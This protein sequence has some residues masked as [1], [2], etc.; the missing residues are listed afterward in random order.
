MAAGTGGEAGAGAVPSFGALASG[1][2]V[3]ASAALA[4]PG[5]Y[6]DN[7]IPQTTFRLRNDAEFGINQFDRASWMFGTWRD[8]S[9]NPKAFVNGNSVHGIYFSPKSTG[10][11]I[12]SNQVN[13]DVL[14]GYAEYAFGQRFSVF[15]EVPY[16]FVHFGP[17]L[18]NMAESPAQMSQFPDADVA[19]PKQD[20]SGISDLQFGFKYAVIAEDSRYVTFQFRTYAPTGDPGL[21]LGTGHYSLEPSLLLYQRLTDRVITQGELEYWIPISGGPGAGN[22]L[23]YGAGISYDLVQRPGFR[24]TPV[25]EA[26]GWTVIGGTEAFAG[27]IPAPI[28]QVPYNPTVSAINVNGVFVPPDRGFRSAT[29]DTIVNLKI[30]VRT[31]FRSSDVYIGYGHS[32]TGSRWY[33]DVFRVEYRFRF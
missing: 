9:A 8:G 16:R 10:T 30:G 20:P 33:E 5:G 17:S 2:G 6:L 19:N 31:Y 18:E 22:V 4:A 15:A 12:L 29:G 26:V 32:V 13:L 7:P 24:L 1:A 28:V 11:Q 27:T 21:G 3:G 14:S 25:A 23:T